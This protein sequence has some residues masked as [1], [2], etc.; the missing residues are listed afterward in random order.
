MKKLAKWMSNSTKVP[1]AAPAEEENARREDAIAWLPEAE[2]ELRRSTR[3][4]CAKSFCKDSGTKCDPT[5][6]LLKAH[7]GCRIWSARKS[8]S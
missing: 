5:A 8:K 2:P 4:S 6:G 7:V 3:S 1:K